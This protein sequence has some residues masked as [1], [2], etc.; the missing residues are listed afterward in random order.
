MDPLAELDDGQVPALVG[1]TERVE[2]GELG[3]LLHE[4]LKLVHELGVVVVVGQ[5]RLDPLTL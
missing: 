3:E 1:L 2:P 5:S 4:A